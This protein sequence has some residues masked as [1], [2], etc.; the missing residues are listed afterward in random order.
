M[1]YL[2]QAKHIAASAPDSVRNPILVPEHAVGAL[3]MQQQR[4][5]Y[6]STGHLAHVRGDTWHAVQPPNPNTLEHAHREERER[7]AVAID[8]IEPDQP[9]TRDEEQPAEE[10]DRAVRGSAHAD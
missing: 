5:R 10:A 1:K 8:E 7:Q 9:A 3:D 6:L 2:R 4:A